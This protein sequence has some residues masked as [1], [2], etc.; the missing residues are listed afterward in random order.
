M[1]GL[2]ELEFDREM[3]KLSDAD[4]AALREGLMTRA[5][6]ASAALERLGHRPAIAPAAA[7]TAAARPRLVEIRGRP[8]APVPAPP[9]QR[10]ASASARSAA[11]DVA[12]AN[13]AANAARRFPY[14]RAPRRGPS[15]DGG[16]DRGTRAWQEFRS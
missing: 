13:S 10:R 3:G 16:A 5:L 6:G 7:T 12:A 15:D 11:R 14:R 9:P 1:Q 4:Y 2:R 8:A